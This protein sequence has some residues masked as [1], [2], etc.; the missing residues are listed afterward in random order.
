MKTR[1]MKSIRYKYP[2][3]FV[4]FML[5]VGLMTTLGINYWISPKLVANEEAIIEGALQDIND[6]ILTE[7]EQVQAQQRTITQTIPLISSEQ[8]DQILP[9]MVD[10]YGK[11]QVFGGGIWPL[12]G[13]R[14]Q[15]VEKY[16]TFYHRDDNNKLV[17]N[18]YWNSAD[19]ANYYEQIWYKNGLTAPQGRC[20]WA[21]AYQDSASNEARTNCAMSIFKQ[22]ERYGVAT[23]DLTLGFFNNL[24]A[25]KEKM[26][27][28]NILII[29][30]DGKILSN[31]RSINR[32]LILEN[33]SSITQQSPFATNVNRHLTQI[34]TSN[35]LQVNYDN[36]GI[37]HT[38]FMHQITDTPWIVAF[39]IETDLIQS[40]TNSIMMILA[41]IQLPIVAAI[42]I[43]CF[44]VFS[45]LTQ[46][47]ESLRNN[48]RSLSSGNADL[49]TVIE[50]NSSD[51]V[52]DIAESV[53]HFIIY[54]KSMI[55]DI[56]QAS[57]HISD[58][59]KQLN[60]QSDNNNQALNEHATET[61][62]VVAAITEL[63]ATA[64]TIAQSAN[65][66]A[67]NTNKASD[68]AQLA[69][70]DVIEASSSMSILV[71]E[72]ATASSSINTMNENTQQIVS[73]LGVIGEIADQTNLLAL[74]AAIEA[75]RAG[76]Q[77][78][79]FAVVADE[80]RS[81]AARTQ[82]STAEINEIL[83]KLRQDATNAVTAME[84]TK[85]SCERTAENAERVSNSLDAMTGSI[86]E[87]SDLSTQIATAS[88][89]Q[90]SVSEEVNRNMNNIRE[91]IYEL[92][93]NS[94]ATVDS[95]QSLSAANSQLDTLV[96][97]FKLQ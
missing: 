27:N 23:I 92:T 64:E 75:A 90:S 56:S 85:A 80:V 35:Q 77:G 6:V 47:L 52:A 91:M 94:Q 22:G 11:L 70:N 29:E 21:P 97:K 89:E 79:G 3:Y 30:S 86:F 42:I 63:S 62:Q 76:E 8:I 55:M 5:V 18:T 88:E 60:V 15:G 9:S 59:I 39:S 12:P 33:L 74:N 19:S 20:A 68:D 83:T 78:R 7:L 71:E 46:R 96:N 25:E 48:I 34:N 44:I 65:D 43:F 17:E 16:S 66:T 53:N 45:K 41:S 32:P 24:V 57:T 58:G 67:A 95:T 87:I 4:F 51:E 36:N 61:D 73:V 2:L 82:T 1:K 84:V 37:N 50:T 72:V 38:L 54:L 10:Q 49:T 31:T 81:L 14:Q 26:L 40:T 28:G 13:K 69:K 93:Q